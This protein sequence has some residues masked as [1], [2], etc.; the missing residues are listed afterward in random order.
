[1]NLTKAKG[2]INGLAIGD[3]MGRLTEFK[4]LPQIK[5]EYGKKGITDLP[6]PALFSDLLGRFQN[7]EHRKKGQRLK[8]KGQRKRRIAPPQTTISSRN[9]PPVS[10]L[11]STVYCLLSTVSRLLSPISPAR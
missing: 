2:L 10:R 5:S 1:M 11:L 8:V 4:S 9:P 6:E 7:F 3:A